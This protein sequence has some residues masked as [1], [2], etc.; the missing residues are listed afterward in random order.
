MYTKRI[1]NVGVWYKYVCLSNYT[2]HLM[3]SLIHITI[4]VLYLLPSRMWTLLLCVFLVL[5]VATIKCWRIHM[6]S[7]MVS[8]LP[9]PPAWP[10]IGHY[11]NFL[12]ISTAQQFHHKFCQMTLQFD[13][14]FK[15]W[16]GPVL[17]IIVQG[18]EHVRA[19]ERCL[20]KA[21]FY[22]FFPEIIHPS[23]VMA[24]GISLYH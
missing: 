15:L 9:S 12:S 20:D 16:I 18:K 8:N 17:L 22:K 5:M 14:T 21:I 7:R 3:F 13:R 24:E 10:I 4:Y 1:N 6:M 23:M 19:A 2:L 11:H